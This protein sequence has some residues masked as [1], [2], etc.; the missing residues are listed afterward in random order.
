MP[1]SISKRHHPLGVR[2]KLNSSKSQ[3]TLNLGVLRVFTPSFKFS[4]SA[5][6]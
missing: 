4:P 1:L 6:H 5:S 3:L 2:N